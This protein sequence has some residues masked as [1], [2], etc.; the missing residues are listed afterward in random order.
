MRLLRPAALLALLA[1]LAVTAL[2]GDVLAEYQTRFKRGRFPD[3]K[4]EVVAE[5]VATAKPDAL[6]ALRWCV[7]SARAWAA[8][9][10]VQGDKLR[11]KA[12]AALAK[13][14]E[15]MQAYFDQQKK[16]GNPN[17]TTRPRFPEDDEYDKLRSTMD[18]LDAEAVG[19]T[20]SAAAALDGCGAL[21]A[22]LTAEQQ[23]SV[24]DDWTRTLLASKD[25]AV[26]AEGYEL[27]GHTT[28]PWATEMLVAAVNASEADARALVVAVDGLAGRD[29]KLVT[30]ALLL[31]VDDVRWL[32]RVAV[33]AAFEATPS[34]EGIDALVRR[35][36]K[37]DG[38]L[39]EDCT[40]A[41]RA[42]TGADIGPL[43]EAWR[44]WWEKNRE[45]W[46][47]KPPPVAAKPPSPF[48]KDEKKP[49]EGERKTGTFFG[50]EIESKRVVFVI[51]VSGSMREPVGGG[52]DPKATKISL[53]KR[54]LKQA[55]GGLE[56]GA[57]FDVVF[58]SAGVKTWK[59]DMQKADAKTRKE[60]QEFTDATEADG[61]TNTYDALDAAFA[62]GDL[63]KGRKRET[64]PT[65]DARMDTIVF[66]SDG[67]PSVGRTTDPDAI[68]AAVREWNRARRI[69]VH[70]VAFGV[71][72]KDGADPKFMEGLAQ[73]T[74][75][76][77]RGM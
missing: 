16:Q 46:N 25:W 43:P 47:G 1:A 50:I 66:L 39:K 70:A 33:V 45:K 49:D 62:I 74:G 35:L 13:L 4:K 29:P 51:D 14:L 42:L 17:P 55:I 71:D 28:T 2:A 22:K 68:R 44:L 76:S 11:G 27:L 56:D 72:A 40:R 5:L 32:V 31:R 10:R 53:A 38:R 59:P 63:G 36:A 64:D 57:L 41:L 34:K 3:T 77:Y 18:S 58:F 52:P 12:D 73:D 23:K 54:E 48:A 21:V 67:K 65:G 26:R 6:K 37:E 60:A 19:E 9:D 69:V 15:K 30:Q 24:R 20:Q 61:G 8:D 7:S 75:G